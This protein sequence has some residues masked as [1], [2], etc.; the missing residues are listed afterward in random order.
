MFLLSL[1]WLAL[2]ALIGLIATAA[3]LQ[4]TAW[5]RRSWRR[6]SALGA[7]CALTGG[8]IALWLLG[9]YSATPLALCLTVVGVI[10]LPHLLHWLSPRTRN[11]YRLLPGTTSSST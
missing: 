11:W 7:L 2:G 8:W 5:F 4:P 6:M 10:T 3:R 1:L 9:Q